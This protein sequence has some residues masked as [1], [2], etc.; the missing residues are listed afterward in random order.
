MDRTVS[1]GLGK[2]EELLAAGTK[3]AGLAT[4]NRESAASQR[5]RRNGGLVVGRLIP[6]PLPAAGCEVAGVETLRPTRGLC[7]SR[8]SRGDRAS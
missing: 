5:R 6:E 8:A 7:D 4:A 2:A 3:S 1:G